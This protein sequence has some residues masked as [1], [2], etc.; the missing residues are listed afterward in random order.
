[1]EPFGYLS[2][3]TVA[4]LFPPRWLP[5]G[6]WDL[7]RKRLNLCR[8]EVR[9]VRLEGEAQGVFLFLL[10]SYQEFARCPNQASRILATYRRASRL[11]CRVIGIS[12]EL[13]AAWPEVRKSL[14]ELVD[15]EYLRALSVVEG[16]CVA[17]RSLGVDPARAT[18][19]LIGFGPGGYIYAE[20]LAQRVRSIVIS[21]RDPTVGRARRLLY[22]KFGVAITTLSPTEAVQAAE[23]VILLDGQLP[24]LTGSIVVADPGQ[25]L[26]GSDVGDA[27]VFE[28]GF[29]D[30]RP[31]G[32][33]GAT[34]EPSLLETILR[35]VK[36][37]A[38][39]E[40]LISAAQSHGFSVAC[41]KREGREISLGGW[42]VVDRGM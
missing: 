26:R 6:L 23:M 31:L 7:L 41:L 24:P 36:K 5:G 18:A 39:A 28:E 11:G 38:S 40:S 35:A 12:S 10:L 16:C 21:G 2:L 30:G 29:F 20:L 1:V 13:L 3:V 17:A 32:W 37:E 34:V 27:L 42:N 15:G 9:E 22:E 8:H 19:A 14:P 4:E 33:P 25:R